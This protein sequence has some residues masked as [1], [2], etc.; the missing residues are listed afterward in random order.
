MVSVEEYILSPGNM[1]YVSL[2]CLGCQG[3]VVTRARS[4]PTVLLDQAVAA[5]TIRPRY[6]QLQGPHDTQTFAQIKF[7]LDRKLK[8]LF[9]R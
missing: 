9:K 8:T 3:S 5:L 6:R 1:L 7:S 4:S 2:C